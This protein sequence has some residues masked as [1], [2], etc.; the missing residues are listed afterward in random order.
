MRGLFQGSNWLG[1]A[2]L[3]HPPIME[4]A[5]RIIENVI[6]EA[7]RQVLETVDLTGMK[8]EDIYEDQLT[9]ALCKHIDRLRLQDPPLIPGFSP[10]YFESVQRESNWRDCQNISI[11]KQPDLVFKFYGKRPCV[12]SDS[13]YY[14]GL[15]VECKPIDSKHSVQRHYLDK[16]L[17]RFVDGTYA[18]AM[19]DA[20]MLGYTNDGSNLGSKLI[21]ALSKPSVQE[22][23][24]MSGLPT[25]SQGD[26]AI[27]DRC[28]TH[29]IRECIYP[30]NGEKAG[31][32][33]I[34]HLWLGY[35]RTS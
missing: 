35:E 26:K 7:W 33:R 6:R 22:S 4:G 18:W 12:E 21:P 17:S 29:H 13:A 11:D 30:H 9:E 8:V 19:Q 5:L 32:I 16:G 24:K 3:P 34:R 28:E 23:L 2:Q 20:M 25:P 1:N 10:D 27:S 14:D 15:F 31:S